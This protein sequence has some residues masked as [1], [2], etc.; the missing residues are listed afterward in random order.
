M[1]PM[2]FGQ[3][4]IDVFVEQRFKLDGGMMFG[5]VPKVLWNKLIPADDK[6]FIPMTTNLYV[7]KAYGKNMIFDIGLGDNLSDF[8]KK[9][10][11]VT[12]ESAMTSG[13]TSVGLNSDDIDYVILTHLHTDHAGGAVTI[14]N[15][16]FVPRFKN[17]K[18]IVSKEEWQVAT[19]PTERTSAVYNPD[20]YRALKNAGQLEL[21][22][23]NSEL[24]PGIKAV[25]T[26]GHTEGHFGLEIESEGKRVFYYSDIFPT[27]WHMPVPYIAATDVFPLESM[28][29]KRKVLP[30]LLDENTIVAFNHDTKVTF[31]KVSQDGKKYKVEPVSEV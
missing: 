25:Y 8:E 5:I 28:E 17:A 26:G 31:G 7:L 22:D 29:A 2:K 18:Y 23:A 14:D 11:N 15:G 4:E 9:I 10:Y 20:R 1:R 21:V 19:N 6:N 16:E 27:S 24:F 30:R 13:L 12:E 3:F